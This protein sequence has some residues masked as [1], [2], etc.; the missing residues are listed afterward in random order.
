MRTEG[1][2][3][4]LDFLVPVV[5]GSVVVG[6]F[7]SIFCFRLL[8]EFGDCDDER[9]EGE[10]LELLFDFDVCSISKRWNENTNNKHHQTTPIHKINVV[11][12]TFLAHIQMVIFLKKIRTLTA[13]MCHCVK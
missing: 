4:C 5:V 9:G 3:R 7:S 6:F 13:G 2:W 11:H 12:K 8:N 10:A 1:A